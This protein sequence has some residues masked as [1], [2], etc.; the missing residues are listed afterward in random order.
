[1][2]QPGSIKHSS[3]TSHIFVFLQLL[4]TK[5]RPGL[6]LSRVYAGTPAQVAVLHMPWWSRD[7][8][9]TQT[10]TISYDNLIQRLWVHATANMNIVDATSSSTNE[11]IIPHEAWVSILGFQQTDPVTDFRSGGILSLA[12]MVHLVESCPAVYMRYATGDAAVLPFAITSINVT[13]MLSRFLMLAKSVDRMD[14]LLSQK[15]FWRMFA[16]PNALLACQELSMDLLADVVVELQMERASNATADSDSSSSAPPPPQV[17]VFDFTG[18]LETTE[19]RVQYD[20]LGAGPKS[21]P[22]LRQIHARIKRKYAQELQVRLG[23]NN[24]HHDAALADIS[25][26]LP[27]SVLPSASAAAALNHQAVLSKANQV[28]HGA[29]EMAGSMLQKL[30][31]GAPG[32]FDKL[33]PQQSNA[34]TGSATTS[35]VHPTTDQKDADATTTTSTTTTT[36]ATSAPPLSTDVVPP[37]TSPTGSDSDDWVDTAAAGVGNFSIGGD[38]DE[39]DDFL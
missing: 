19:R 17:S 39:E 13:D 36:S 15:T 31:R 4:H 33:Q 11:P 18:I 28:A 3:H 35:N 14:A 27:S 20:L 29:Q 34:T 6:K 30:K 24:D 5:C 23:H 32:L 12:M 9:E 1:M 22:A 8:Q 2:K 38:D 26:S 16:D 37:Q 25:S 21:V 10:M 7:I